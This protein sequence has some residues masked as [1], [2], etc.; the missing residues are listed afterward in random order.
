[1]QEPPPTFEAVGFANLIWLD[2]LASWRNPRVAIVKFSIVSLV[3]YTLG[4]I[5][6]YLHGLQNI[7]LTTPGFLIGSLGILITLTFI[8]YGS[9]TQYQMFERLMR[10]FSLTPKQRQ[11]Y[12]LDVVAR[13]SNF[14]Q[15]LR[16][17]IIIVVVG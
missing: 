1:M 4:I 17:T 14:R 13:H 5:V 16:A 7:Y 8:S 9:Y 10:C 6:A 15:H 3:P 11:E 2:Y 12:T